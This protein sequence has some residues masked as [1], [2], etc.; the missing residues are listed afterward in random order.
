MNIIYD[1]SSITLFCPLPFFKCYRGTN[2][3]FQLNGSSYSRQVRQTNSTS[4]S[5]NGH[6]LGINACARICI[7][8]AICRNESRMAMSSQGKRLIHLLRS[9]EVGSVQDTVE[10]FDSTRFTPHR[11]VLDCTIPVGADVSIN[12]FKISKWFHNYGYFFLQ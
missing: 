11:D 12:W 9:A 6:I 7:H 1:T 4:D 8:V 3:I 10:R 2:F 5:R